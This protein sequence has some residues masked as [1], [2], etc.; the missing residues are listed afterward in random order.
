MCQAEV[1]PN[2]RQDEEGG[3]EEGETVRERENATAMTYCGEWKGL[4]GKLRLKSPNRLPRKAT[5]GSTDTPTDTRDTHN[6]HLEPFPCTG[7]IYEP[8]YPAVQARLGRQSRRGENMYPG[9]PAVFTVRGEERRGE[10]RRGEERRRE[11]R[12]GVKIRIPKKHK[13]FSPVSEPPELEQRSGRSLTGP[14]AAVTEV[15]PSSV[16]DSST[17][18]LF[19]LSYHANDR[20]PCSQ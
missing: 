10:E 5:V 20:V 18:R 1:P 11:E 4:Q 16:Y 12:R 14:N 8:G 17:M 9:N 13:V 7:G 15:D 6:K 19:R 3:E 2:E